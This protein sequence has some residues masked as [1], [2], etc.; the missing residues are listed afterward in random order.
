MSASAASAK[1]ARVI[2]QLSNAGLDMV[3]TTH[4][5]IILQHINNMIRLA[6]REDAKPVC[7]K[8]GYTEE[9][10]LNVEKVK[11]YQF[12]SEAGRMTKVE[13][14]VCGKNGFVIPTFNNALDRIMDEAYLI[15]E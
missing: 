1:M 11:V 12:K 9:D 8:L 10:L 14:L 13:E 2:C 6:G 15:Q 4:S 5:D 3:V 7:Q